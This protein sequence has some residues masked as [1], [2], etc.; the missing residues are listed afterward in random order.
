[1]ESDRK[2][3]ALLLSPI[4]DDPTELPPMGFLY[5]A[6]YLRQHPRIELYVPHCSLTPKNSRE[7]LAERE[8]DVI[9]T[10]GMLTFVDTFVRFLDDARVLQPQALRVLGGPIVSA[11]PGERLFSEL[12]FHVGV[13]GEGEATL[14]DLLLA[15]ADGRPFHQVPGLLCRGLDG[16]ALV[17]EAR[18]PINLKKCNIL[19][20]WSICDIE[21]YFRHIGCRVLH[22]LGSRGCPNRCHYCNSTIR[23]YRI[24][25]V[26]QV[27]DEIRATHEQ[28]RLEGLSFRDETFMANPKRIRE[29]CRAYMDSGIGLPWG[30]GLR[31]NI[32]DLETLRLMREAGCTEIQYG[33]ES[34]SARVLKRMNKHVTPADNLRAIRET[35][36]AGINRG[37]S[38]MFGYLEETKDDVRA[39]IDLLMEANELPKY[40]S[41]TTPVPGTPLFDDCAAR[42]LVDDPV[43]HA[44]I[45]NKAIYLAFAPKLN[46]TGIED[47]ELFP[48]LREELARLY[49]AHFRRNHAWLLEFSFGMGQ[50]GSLRAACSHCGKE[51]AERVGHPKWSYQLFCPNCRNHTWVHL[52]DVPEYAAHFDAVRGFLD[53][54]DA[55]GGA[56]VLRATKNDFVYGNMIKVDPFGRVMGRR[57]PVISETQ[58]RFHLREW[59]R[60]APPAQSA[61]ALVMDMDPDRAY[62]VEL[63][64]LGFAPE[65]IMPVLPAPERAICYTAPRPAQAWAG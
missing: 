35:Q 1:M 22:F 19:P 16:R 11:F 33:V 27:V 15:H 5:L 54:L 10:G 65:R 23:G 21:A 13:V 47:A 55:Q 63:A 61:W 40:Y 18:A 17:T 32:A 59:D 39:T 12:D 37:V 28:Y 56:L 58:Y 50:G 45:M 24:R 41:L 44:R 62:A 14:E 38:V 6:G 7:L 49:T 4:Y 64:A 29:F 2:I 48:F 25:A 51:L 53:R 60:A 42:G 30:C 20:D 34:G 36:A 8:Y 43:A 3:R 9:C 26:D 52:A 46:M 31:T 57:P